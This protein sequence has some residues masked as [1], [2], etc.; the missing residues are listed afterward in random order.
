MSK[1]EKRVRAKRLRSLKKW[2]RIVRYSGYIGASLTG[3]LSLW[4][5]MVALVAV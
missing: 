4:L 3:M 2:A 5:L 1:M